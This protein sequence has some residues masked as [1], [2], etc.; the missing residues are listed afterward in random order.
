[1]VTIIYCRYSSDMQRKE[2]CTD[3]ERKVREY[4]LRN[5]IPTG[6]VRPAH[7][8][9]PGRLLALAMDP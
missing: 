6:E 8:G 5:N 1:M 3:Q 7:K 2:S 4:L 9:R